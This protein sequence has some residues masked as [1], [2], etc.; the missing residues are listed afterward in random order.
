[1]FEVKV[2]GRFSAAH[3]LRDY[4]GDCEKLHG[5]NYLVELTATGKR[6]KDGMVVDF[7]VLK[8]T[9]ERVLDELDHEYLNELE[10]FR[11]HNTTTENIAEYIFTEVSAAL[12]EGVKLRRVCAWE[13]DGSGVTYSPDSGG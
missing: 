2:Q 13:T 8:K 10:Y 11:E 7:R 12:P 6:G 3:N 4:S 9:L 5:H 1:M